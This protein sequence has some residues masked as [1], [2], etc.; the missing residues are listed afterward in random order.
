MVYCMT[1]ITINDLNNYK[2]TAIGINHYKSIINNTN[3][4]ILEG[5]STYTLLPL[6]DRGRPEPVG[7]NSTCSQGDLLNLKAKH[8]VVKSVRKICM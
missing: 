4:L 6:S 3:T 1:F 2:A 8:Q 7:T 5:P